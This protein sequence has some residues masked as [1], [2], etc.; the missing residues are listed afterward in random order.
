MSV[1]IVNK[2]TELWEVPPGQCLLARF[3]AD[4]DWFEEEIQARNWILDVAYPL[5][6]A[7]LHPSFTRF[8]SVIRT[9]VALMGEGE[10][11]GKHIRYTD[12]GGSQVVYAVVPEAEYETARYILFGPKP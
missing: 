6:M 7:S 10:G 5:L 12:R 9:E 11:E 8:R 3:V 1:T 4:D 2:V